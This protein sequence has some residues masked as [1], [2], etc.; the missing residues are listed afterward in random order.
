MGNTSVQVI[1]IDPSSTST[2][3]AATYDAGVFKS[4]DS[5][6]NWSAVN[7]GLSN[8][9]V[10]ALA[11]DPNN[12]NTLYAGTSLNLFALMYAQSGGGIFKSTDA[13][14][15][16][17]AINTGLG[18]GDV[19][20]IVVDPQNSSRVYAGLSH[21]VIGYHDGIGVYNSADGGASWGR[22]NEGMG[23][24]SV[25][26]MAIDP[27]NHLNLYAATGFMSVVNYTIDEALGISTTPGSMDFGEVKVNSPSTTKQFTITN[28]GISDLTLSTLIIFGGDAND[29]ILDPGPGPNNCVSTWPVLSPGEACTGVIA[30]YP[31]S[32]GAKTSSFY[33]YSD[34]PET[35]MV[36]ISLSGTGTV[37]PVPDINVAPLSLNFGSVEAGSSSLTNTVTIENNGSANLN[38]SAIYLGGTNPGEF[39]LDLSGGSSPC[40]SDTLTLSSGTFCT[41]T[42]TFEPQTAGPKSAVLEVES[43]DPDTA[44]KSVTI[45]GT[46]VPR[47]AA[48]ISLSPQTMDM[49]T[50]NT[51]ETS[52]PVSITISNGG[53]L[54]LH[55]LNIALSG[56]DSGDFVLDLSGG[57][58]PCGSASA[59]LAPGADCTVTVTFSP[60]TIGDRTASLDVSSDD[61]A[62]GVA[63]AKLSGTGNLAV[64]IGGGSGGGCGIVRAYGDTNAP[65]VKAAR[66]FRD[67]YLMPYSLGRKIVDRYYRYSPLLEEFISGHREARAAVRAIVTPIVFFV[68]H[69]PLLILC[70]LVML[71]IACGPARGRALLF[72]IKKLLPDTT[73]QAG[74]RQL[75][76]PRHARTFVAGYSIFPSQISGII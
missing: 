68:E 16:W 14:A 42:V 40:Y 15:S 35:P 56:P 2:L 25:F 5:G 69:T 65:E 29:F 23:N 53:N 27:D 26:D 43:D 19:N 34:D 60:D 39:T 41:V 67:R 31:L 6:A 64:N 21:S 44:L 1:V 10:T 20:V 70:I 32:E 36:T 30:F 12:T 59:V 62:N 66:R 38:V 33:I 49:G 54:D 46:G 55:V 51:G 52:E 75:L 63:S 73:V 22:M 17:S 24:I 71:I 3:Y 18:S 72:I 11:I 57:A 8:T 13:G 7:S 76:I 47:P 58:T 61:P 37:D 4:T 48:V 50:V 74:S 9:T 45:G 28:N